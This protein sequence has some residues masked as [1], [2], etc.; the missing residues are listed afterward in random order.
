ML[1]KNQLQLHLDNKSYKGKFIGLIKT[2]DTLTQFWMLL[3]NSCKSCCKSSPSPSFFKKLETVFWV[4]SNCDPGRIGLRLAKYLS[5][6]AQVR[7]SEAL[8]NPLFMT[9]LRS[10]QERGGERKE[11][12]KRKVHIQ[13]FTLMINLRDIHIQI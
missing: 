11:K 8:V 9:K 7:V 12:S 10:K 1:K 4:C 3:A 2:N 13:C 5:R 6:V